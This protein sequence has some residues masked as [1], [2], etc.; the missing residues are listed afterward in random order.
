MFFGFFGFGEAWG[1]WFL[2]VFCSSWIFFVSLCFG[3][4]GGMVC[5]K[6]LLFLWLESLAICFVGAIMCH[7]TNKQPGSQCSKHDLRK[8]T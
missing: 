3:G 6:V 8:N 7:P 4:P 2:G 1:L 5:P